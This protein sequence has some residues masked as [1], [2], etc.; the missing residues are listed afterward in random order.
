M[1][2]VAI[3]VVF[4]WWARNYSGVL[5]SIHIVITFRV[6]HYRTCLLRLVRRV[7]RHAAP[8]VSGMN[9][10]NNCH[11]RS[12]STLSMPRSYHTAMHPTCHSDSESEHGSIADTAH[13]DPPSDVD[14]QPSTP[15]DPQQL[16]QVAIYSPGRSFT[17][18]DRDQLP[19]IKSLGYGDDAVTGRYVIDTLTEVA[20]PEKFWD[21]LRRTCPDREYLALRGYFKIV[22]Q[23]QTEWVA[24]GRKGF[25]TKSIE[26]LSDAQFRLMQKTLERSWKWKL[27]KGELKH[28]ISFLRCMRIDFWPEEGLAVAIAPTFDEDF[29]SPLVGVVEVI[30]KQCAS[31][32][33]AHL[34]KHSEIL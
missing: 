4:E 11:K 13:S 9:S 24:V 10:L 30:M 20:I 21:L 12:T 27:R 31:G 7:A 32:K 17:E 18:N 8:L 29:T 6:L 25:V 26:G 34:P 16:G 3:L 33:T 2:F 19:V 14:T 23:L 5:T 22:W 28:W 1:H 15:P